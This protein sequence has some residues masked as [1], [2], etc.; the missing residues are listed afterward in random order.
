MMR[1][2]AGRVGCSSLRISQEMEF[3]RWCS[4]T[5][6]YLPKPD[7]GTGSPGRSEVVL[8]GH[9]WKTEW[10]GVLMFRRAVQGEGL[11][12]FHM[13]GAQLSGHMLE[14]GAGHC[15]LDCGGLS[16]P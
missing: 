10:S 7:F 1:R 14:C 5:V 6:S 16:H 12:V 11:C 15:F 3:D 9:H 8:D 4:V 2:G 13:G